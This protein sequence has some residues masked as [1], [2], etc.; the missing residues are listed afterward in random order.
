MAEKITEQ[1]QEIFADK[2]QWDQF[3]KLIT[4]KDNIK[5][6]WL[7]KLKPHLNE[8]FTVDNVVDEWEFDSTDGDYRWY[9]KEYG[10]GSLYLA[11]WQNKNEFQFVLYAEDEKLNISLLRKEMRK[12]EYQHIISAFDRLD[13]LLEDDEDRYLIKEIGNFSFGDISD[14]NLDVDSLAWYANYKTDD[15]VLQIQQKVDKFIK[16]KDITKLFANLID[17]TK[18]LPRLKK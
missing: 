15:F 14:T 9:L 13:Y 17:S 4:Q 11:F 16:N 6:D 10:R 8:I 1:V 7:G 5:N 3:L 12:K 18:I 2:E